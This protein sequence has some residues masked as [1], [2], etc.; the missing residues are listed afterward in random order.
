ME[1]F[2]T[3]L[4]D[5]SKAV[6]NDQQ[7]K[8]RRV[9][10]KTVFI[11]SEDKKVTKGP[12]KLKGKRL[13]IKTDVSTADFSA[14]VGSPSSEVL[15]TDGLKRKKKGSFQDEPVVKSLH[16]QVDSLVEFFSSFSAPE[17]EHD[18]TETLEKAAKSHTHTIGGRNGVWRRVAG[19]KCFICDEGKVRVGP[20]SFIDK[21]VHSL[22]D[23]LRAER[24]SSKG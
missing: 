5:L 23:E 14:Q 16:A 20:P 22:A 6:H 18:V 15:L 4:E 17:L 7:G 9:A 21:S 24:A 2:I 8:Y 13:M 3:A 11:R 1:D 12:E 10:G 19:R